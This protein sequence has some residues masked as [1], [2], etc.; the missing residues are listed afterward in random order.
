V[1]QSSVGNKTLD[2][3]PGYG[4][5]FTETRGDEYEQEISEILMELWVL[6]VDHNSYNEI[7]P[8]SKTGLDYC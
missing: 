3:S 5:H 6:Q 4:S 7:W 2:D 1:D 8:P